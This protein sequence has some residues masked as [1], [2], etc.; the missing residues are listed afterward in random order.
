MNIFARIKNA[1]TN[2]TTTSLSTMNSWFFNSA[3]SDLGADISEI[4]Y[5]TC[6]KT[7]SE[8]L[9]KMPV[10]LM[11][12]NKKRV[13]G[14]ET[15]PFLSV[16]PNDMMTPVQFFTRLEYDRNHYGNAYVYVDR[17]RGRLRGLYHL[18][19]QMVQIWVNNTE[20]FTRRKYYYYFTDERSGKSY[21]I[22]PQDML[23]FKSWVTDK[24]GLAGKSVR[25]ILAT[26]MAGSKASQKF[27]NDLYQKGLTANAVVK[28]V[29]DLN[30]ESQKVLLKNIEAQA[31]DD[32][33]RMITL[34]VGYDI[35]TLDLK[36]TDSQF[37]ELKKYNALQVAA[38]FGVKPDHL[39]DYTKSSYASSSM[40]NLSFYVNTLLYNITMYEQELNRKLL[41]RAE[42]NAGLGFKF[43]FWTILRGDP[44][45]QA[46]VLQKMVAS[47]IYSP[48]EARSKLDMEPCD[49]GDVHIIN[50][51]YVRLE[52]IG[53][54]YQQDSS[55][56]NDDSDGA[57]NE[58]N[59][60]DV[61]ENDDSGGDTT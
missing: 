55:N 28:Y 20:S 25:E 48:N 36:L 50:G 9:G 19:P 38:A 41:T 15:S 14:H 23:H 5:F 59:A 61:Q 49:G 30:R 37:Y 58:N 32:S 46:D 8:A 29:G 7:L 39:N 56:Q 22:D 53:L 27:L 52:D 57:E 11:D 60:Q 6:L 34:P 21:W 44:S 33:R 13:L 17:S 26:N 4:T 42:Q 16:Q 10:Y 40:Q 1:F 35:Q 3:T 18:D 43:N 31:R 54:A 24:S 2:G 45:Q 51:S 12:T 47:A